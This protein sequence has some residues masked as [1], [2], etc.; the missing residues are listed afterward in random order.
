VAGNARLLNGYSDWIEEPSLPQAMPDSFTLRTW[1]KLHAYPTS[2]YGMVAA[3]Y[4]GNYKG[5]FLA[6]T[7]E[8][9]VVFL[10]T[11]APSVALWLVAS[12]VLALERWYSISVTYHRPSGAG[13]LYL[14]GV[15][16]AQFFLP[17]MEIES[18]RPLTFGRS[19]WHNGYYLNFAIDETRIDP[20][21]RSATGVAADFATFTPPAPVPNPTLTAEWTFTNQ[22]QDVSGNAHH[23]S[24]LGTQEIPGV[25]GTAR[26][27][28]GSSTALTAP[29]AAR[30]TPSRFTMRAWVRL[31]AYPSNFGIVAANYGG[32]YQGW[33]AAVRSDGRVIVSQSRLPGSALWTVSNTPLAL[34][35]WYHLTITFDGW[36]RQLKIYVDGA[37][38][39]QDALLGLTP[40]TAGVFTAG[41]SSWHNGY[42]L[43]F[44]LDELRLTP[45]ALS[46]VQVQTDFASFPAQ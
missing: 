30:L 37:L 10:G 38:D 6:L 32:N 8:G 12:P 43:N 45:A 1:I 39:K 27:F 3:S 28:S 31:Q 19:S 18:N 33:F 2:A 40:Q 46:A 36:L 23:G 17:G 35:R 7:A 41:K 16:R 14:D 34:N 44:D 4:G 20:V 25:L 42:Y 21:A 29:A 9:K 11:K 26:R 24:L 13:V 5:W 22:A 15:A